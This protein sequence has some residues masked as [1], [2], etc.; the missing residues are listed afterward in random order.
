MLKSFYLFKRISLKLFQL[1]LI[2]S[3]LEEISSPTP[4]VLLSIAS[5]PGARG[6]REL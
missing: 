3:P 6:G 4:R 1:I 2:D 5:F